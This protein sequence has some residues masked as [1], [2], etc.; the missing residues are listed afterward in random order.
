M[1]LPCALI[2]GTICEQARNTDIEQHTIVSVREYFHDSRGGHGISS[3]DDIGTGFYE[4][5]TLSMAS[6]TY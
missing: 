5:E 6:D 1:E 2:R 4:R 3:L